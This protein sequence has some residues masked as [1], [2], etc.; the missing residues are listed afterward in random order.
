MYINSKHLQI[1]KFIKSNKDISI[2]EIGQ[3]F[4][5]S[6]QYT[7]LHLETIYSELFN[8]SFPKD[9]ELIMKIYTAPNS[10]NRLRQ[11][12]EFT[13]N[14]KIFYL[15]F[16][17][18]IT[19]HIKLL[20]ISKEL[21]ITKRNI[22]NY[23]DKINHIFNIFS[24]K[25]NIS[26]K[27]VKI[28]GTDF[29]IKRITLFIIFK[30][31]IEKD[32]LP[33]RFRKEALIFFKI[34]NFYL[35]KKDIIELLNTI[36]SEIS[37]YHYFTLFSFLYSF[38]DNNSPNN[39]QNIPLENILKHKPS[40][41]TDCFFL[42]IITLLKKSS[43]STLS[44]KYLDSLFNIIDIFFYSKTQ[45][46]ESTYL[47]V[48]KI[49]PI[50]YKYLGKQIAN[51]KDLFNLITPWIEYCQIKSLF[52]IEDSSFLNIS[53]KDISNSNLFKMV[54]E[55]QKLIPTFTLYEAL[56]L[57]YKLYFN[58]YSN[59]T[60]ILVYKNIHSD[61]IPSL[62]DEIYKIHS[63]II[64][65]SVNIKFINNY[66]KNNEVNNIVTVENLNIYNKNISI[67]NVSFP[68]PEHRKMV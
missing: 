30:F 9:S 32:F 60:N 37:E 12:Q 42:K 20:H 39:L 26:N 16:K 7:K 21:N 45:Y 57:W 55:I 43:F 66:L 44:I 17:L 14:Q 27:G 24:I 67:M 68:I 11:V 64:H 22:N 63:I 49:Q 48:N 5:L 25:L 58:Q 46:S 61:I 23:F 28:I 3:I 41:Y 56:F 51:N 19:K 15:L 6:P 40:R 38:S 54:K 1:L 53:L 34:D 33:P 62:I 65:D 13:K 18:V 10:K 59:Q 31:L 4:S 36:G 35:L 50:F 8:E 52:F 29:S 47:S 2:H